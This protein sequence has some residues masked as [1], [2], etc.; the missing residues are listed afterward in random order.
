VAVVPG[1]T[2]QVH[3]SE[4]VRELYEHA[5]PIAEGMAAVPVAVISLAVYVAQKLVTNA[6]L[7]V[8]IEAQEWDSGLSH[9]KTA[10]SSKATTKGVKECMMMLGSQYE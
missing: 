7:A 5:E 1:V 6:A 9:P 8:K 3:C 4:M 10:G 2:K